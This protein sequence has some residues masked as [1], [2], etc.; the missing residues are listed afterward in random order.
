MWGNESHY[1]FAV[2]LM[3]I[4]V[5]LYGVFVFKCNYLQ[6][7]LIRATSKMNQ[8]PKDFKNFT[9]QYSTRKRG[10]VCLRVGKMDGSQEVGKELNGTKLSFGHAD[11]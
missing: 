6:F 8:L 10:A 7:C 1:P 4:P 2:P 3:L 5:T 11:S 9:S